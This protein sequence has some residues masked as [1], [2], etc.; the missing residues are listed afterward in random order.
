MTPSERVALTVVR[1]ATRLLAR[2]RRA[3]YLEQWQADVHGATELGVSPLRLAAG[4]LG[5][6]ALIA[7]VDRK[8][9]RT[10]LPIG[11]LA[12]ALRL[13]GGAGARRRA[14]ALAAVF[15]LALLAGAG[16]LIAG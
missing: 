10:M 13:V 14:A 6:A 11:P 15:T 16:L 8:E 3:R 5:A 1:C 2:E 12:L 4:I 7:V 9:T